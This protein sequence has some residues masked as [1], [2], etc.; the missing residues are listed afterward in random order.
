MK[1][2]NSRAYNIRS[3]LSLSAV[4]V[5]FMLMTYMIVV[6]DEPGTIPL[7]L[8]TSGTLLYLYN[9]MKSKTKQAG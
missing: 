6:E 4:A 9:C 3:F 8:I 1:S 5:G 7:F 2:D